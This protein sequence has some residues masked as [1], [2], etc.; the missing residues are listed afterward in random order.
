MLEELNSYLTDAPDS[1]K[2]SYNKL[3]NYFA[4]NLQEVN[5]IK[6]AAKELKE[7]NKVVD[8]KNKPKE[9]KDYTVVYISKTG[10]VQEKFIKA[11]SK[12]E[13]KDELPEGSTNIK[14]FESKDKE[15]IQKYKYKL[16]NN[17]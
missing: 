17:K 2:S 7:Q 13:A 9:D 16:R 11:K 5:I 10:T 3:M 12:S 14:V 6:D 4:V 1:V 8:F 15:S